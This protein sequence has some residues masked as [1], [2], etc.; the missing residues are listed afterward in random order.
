MVLTRETVALI[1]NAG[2]RATAHQVDVRNAE[3]VAQMAMAVLEQHDGVDIL[4]NNAGHATEATL[5]E[6]S[7]DM[8][9]D[10]IDT[11]LTSAFLCTKEFARVFGQS[12]RG[13]VVNVGS[14]N[15]AVA[16]RALGAYCAAKSGL[17][18]L[19]RALALE[20]ASQEIRVNCVAPGVIRTTAFET[21]QSEARKGWFSQLHA[22]G[23]VGLP[24][25]V[26]YAV[27]F[28]CSDLASF[29]TGAVLFVDGGLTVQFGLEA[30]E[31][32]ASVRELES[33]MAQN[34]PSLG[35]SL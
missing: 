34:G 21:N 30:L 32:Q 22:L 23:R 17:H 1:E 10:I 4:V 3:S 19:T 8:W 26:A 27:S 14:I 28:L 11:N 29:I 33:P 25:E 16:M 35:G 12:G 13:V 6:T 15:G 5:A 2:G 7:V 24:E 18:Q 31:T 9:A 20:L